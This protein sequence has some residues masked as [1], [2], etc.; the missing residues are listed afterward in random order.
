MAGASL[1]DPQPKQGLLGPYM[2]MELYDVAMSSLTV[3]EADCLAQLAEIIG[4]DKEAGMLR[5]RAERLRRLIR[6]HLWVED[7]GVFANKF[8]SNETFYRR[9]SPTSFLPL[10][11]R[12]A[13]DAQATSMVRNWLHSPKHFCIAPSGDSAGNA[14]SCWWG[15]PSIAASDPAYDYTGAAWRGDVWGPL[16]LLT[17]W[18]LQEYD[19]LPVVRA[20]RQALVRQ[21]SAM[22]ANVW[23]AN[24]HIC[25]RFGPLKGANDCTGGKF[26]HWGALPFLEELI[27]HGLMNAS[28]HET[29]PVADTSQPQCATEQGIDYD[30][31]D[32]QPV[33]SIP[34]PDAATCCALCHNRTGCVAWSL[35]QFKGCKNCCYLKSSAA[36]RRRFKG[37]VSGT[38]GPAPPAPPPPPPP[39]PSDGSCKDET[40]CSLGGLCVQSKCRCDPAFT[41]PNCAAIALAP[42]SHTPLW[43]APPRTAS[44]G[45]NAVYDRS[46]RKWHLFFAE[47]L[48]HCGL[49][50]WGTNSVVSHAIADEPA[51]PYTK[52]GVVQP[53]FHHNPS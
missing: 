18:S 46:D 50:S 19:H 1:L 33:H 25:E 30:G 53:A 44:W 29:A 47:F 16:T 27:E 34:A 11:A 21:M 22:A 9:I 20:G 48:N 12:A 52:Q 38:I 8:S 40:D 28:Q 36:G 14:D 4:R 35:Q 39:R 10:F 51:G 42:A 23:N 49:D 26:Y 24:R 31:H 17:Y 37:A 3:T 7:E 43:N 2:Q 13:T 15:L 41:G 6:Q 45:G 5:Q 32:L